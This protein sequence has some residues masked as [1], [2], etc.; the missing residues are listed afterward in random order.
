MEGCAGKGN[1]VAYPS[2]DCKP[3]CVLVGSRKEAVFSILLK[4]TFA[5]NPSTIN[6]PWSHKIYNDECKPG[7]RLKAHN[8]RA[9]QAVYISFLGFQA[10][11]LS[12][13]DFWIPISSVLSDD[14]NECEAGVAQL[15]K[16]ILRNMLSTT[17]DIRYSGINFELFD[18]SMLKIWCSLEVVLADESALHQIWQSKGSGGVKACTMCKKCIGKMW[19]AAGEVDDSTYYTL[20]TDTVSLDQCDL[21]SKEYITTI[22]DE[23]KNGGRLPCRKDAGRNVKHVWVGTTQTIVSCIARVCVLR[24]IHVA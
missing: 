10:S 17:H 1:W 22:L 4:K 12:K 21:A 18:G 16:E 19:L 6:N 2:G 8:H 20:Y 9:M 5:R 7:N 13:E 11:N 23:L 24:W 3:R 14:V 15:M